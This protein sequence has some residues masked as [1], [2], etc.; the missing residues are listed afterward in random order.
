[1]RHITY[2][3]EAPQDCVYSATMP[4]VAMCSYSATEPQVETLTSS[5]YSA[6]APQAIAIWTG[7]GG[8]YR[9]HTGAWFALWL[10]KVVAFGLG[11]PTWWDDPPPMTPS[12]LSTA[13]AIL[14]IGGL[15]RRVRCLGRSLG[16]FQTARAM[17]CRAKAVLRE[18]EGC[19][20]IGR[21]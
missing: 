18:V 2:S 1:M 12:I 15:A 14:C 17:A 10:L 6:V 3:A 16:S 5:Q 7:Y 8:S 4:Q 19:L 20:G 13:L 9:M 11:G 21:G